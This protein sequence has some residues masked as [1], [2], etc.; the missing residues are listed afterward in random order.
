M[1]QSS[2]TNKV[3]RKV[4]SEVT[5][6]I[7]HQRTRNQSYATTGAKRWTIKHFCH[8]SDLQDLISCTR[9]VEEVLPEWLVSLLAVHVAGGN[10]IQLAS[11][12]PDDGSE[13]LFHTGCSDPWRPLLWEKIFCCWKTWGKSYFKKIIIKKNSQMKGKTFFFKLLKNVPKFSSHVKS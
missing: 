13:R 1:S 3:F 8:N 2:F 4:F 5:H 10:M 9:V 12:K 7:H 11:D 6:N